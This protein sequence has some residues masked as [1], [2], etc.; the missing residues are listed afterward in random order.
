MMHG[1]QKTEGTLFDLCLTQKMC[2]EEATRHY[3]HTLHTTSSDT[4]VSSLQLV[5]RRHTDLHP[6]S[7]LG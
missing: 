4:P 2:M 6:Q 1:S 3:T 5:K 7:V